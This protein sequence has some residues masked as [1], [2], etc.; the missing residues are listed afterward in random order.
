MHT[1]DARM[2]TTLHSADDAG[3]GEPARRTGPDE[4]EDDL[5]GRP[6]IPLSDEDLLEYQPADD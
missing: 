4:G 6:T 5:E 1:H 2:H 3:P